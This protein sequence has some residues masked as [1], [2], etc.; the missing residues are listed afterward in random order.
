MFTPFSVFHAAPVQLGYSTTI[1]S[2]VAHPFF[3]RLFNSPAAGISTTSP[4]TVMAIR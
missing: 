2:M 1:I 4:M 3:T